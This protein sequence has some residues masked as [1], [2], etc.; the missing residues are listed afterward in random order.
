MPRVD[1][2]AHVAPDARIGD[3]TS[4]CG[5]WPRSRAGAALGRGVRHRARRLRRGRRACS[6]TGSR[7]RTSPWSTSRPCSRTVSSSARPPCSP[8]TSTPA[9]STPTARSSRGADWDAVGVDR[10]AT[11]ASVGARAVCVA[12]VT[13]GRW[14]MV[15]A[16][17]VVTHGRARLRPGRRRPRPAD[18]LGRPRRPS[19]RG[20]AREDAGAARSPAQLFIE[21]GGRAW[22]GGRASDRPS[23]RRRARRHSATRSSAAVDRGPAP[24]DGSPRAARSRPSSRSSPRLRRRTHLRRGQLRHERACTSACWRRASARATR[25]SSRRS[26]SRRPPTRSR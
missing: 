10:A 25:S 14:A 12:P 26:P 3:G 23:D 24:A 18:R 9:P 5:G 17:A 7:C 19:A 8:T 6:A 11:G 20:E 13:I 22:D 15:A 4:R 16:G 21:T 1:P 2:A